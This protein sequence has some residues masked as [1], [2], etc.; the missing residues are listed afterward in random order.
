MKVSHRNRVRLTFP[1]A[2][3]VRLNNSSGYIVWPDKIQPRGYERPA[4]GFGKTARMA[5]AS[6]QLVDD[7]I[8]KLQIHISGEICTGKTI[9]SHKLAL[10]LAR[11]GHLVTLLDDEGHSMTADKRASGCFKH[12]R[13]I[14]MN[15]RRRMN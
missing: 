1:N 10:F 6:V 13:K 7:K 14:T 3:C 11:E 9:L 4:I 5:W 2:Y 15:K 8:P 12:P